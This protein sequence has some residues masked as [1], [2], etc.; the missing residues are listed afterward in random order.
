MTFTPTYY[1]INWLASPIGDPAFFNAEVFCLVR[2]FRLWYRPVK[3]TSFESKGIIL[4][5]ALRDVLFH[6][7][8]PLKQPAHSLHNSFHPTL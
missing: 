5:E 3:G 7:A 4:P 1:P 6:I 8:P 2:R